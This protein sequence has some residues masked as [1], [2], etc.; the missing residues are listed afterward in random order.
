MN[1]AAKIGLT[2]AGVFGI[3]K[4]V[5]AIQA[6]NVSDEMVINIINPRVHKV[7]TDPFNGGLEIRTEIQL[8]NPTKGKLQITQPHIQV[9]SGETVIISTKVIS[10]LYTVQPLS[11][12]TLDTISLKIGWG[13]IF[14]LITETN[15]GIPQDYTLW[16]KI[17]WFVPNYKEA[18]NKMNLVLKYSTYANG[19]YNVETEKI[20]A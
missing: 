3:S 20:Q 19:L 15:Y 9:L 18:V 5:S 6:K 1:L 11:Q 12:V 10:K 16:Q 4:L 7:N 17:K 2:V 8:Q 14:S 13:K